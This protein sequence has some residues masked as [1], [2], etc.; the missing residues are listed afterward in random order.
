MAVM[1]QSKAR[2]QL[3]ERCRGREEEQDVQVG[4]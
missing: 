4:V 3:Q 1:I 2:R